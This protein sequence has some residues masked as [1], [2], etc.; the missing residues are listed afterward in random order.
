MSDLIELLHVAGAVFVIGPMATLPMLALRAIRTG[1]GTQTRLLAR[2]SLGFGIAAVVVAALGFGA[3]ATADSDRGWSLTTPWILLSVIAVTVACAVHLGVVV[4]ALY[5]A[6]GARGAGS[7]SYALVATTSG[8]VAILMVV[9][10]V[11][12]VVR[13]G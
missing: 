1:D 3:L 8:L 6:S 12:M 10:V 4:P 5:G 7:F 11:L 13:P 2:S 9:V